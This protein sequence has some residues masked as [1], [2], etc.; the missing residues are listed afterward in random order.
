MLQFALW[1]KILVWGLCAAGIV[2]ALPNGFYSRVERHNDAVRSLDIG[3]PRTP[4]LESELYAW[5]AWLPSK[6]VNLGLD[7]RGGAH[8]LAEVEVNDVYAERMDGMWPDIRDALRTR[9]DSIGTIRRQPAEPSELV[10][11]VSRPEN[12]SVAVEAV[13]ALARPLV[14]LTGAGGSDIEAEAVGDTVVVRLSDAEIAA[15]DERTLRQSLEIIRRR[16]DEVGTRE[17]TIQR[18]G[19]KR[20]LIQVPGIGSA[21]ELKEIIG[22][23]ARLTFHPVVTRTTNRDSTIGPRE[24]LLPSLDEPGQFYVLEKTP[25]VGGED[26][27]DAQPGFDQNGLPAVTFRFNPSGA[28]RFGDYTAANIGSPFA[29]VLDGEVVSA[30]VIQ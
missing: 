13:R 5:P 15:T 25:V 9:R 7:L 6:I 10:V 3:E 4:Q 17:P 21:E 30:P 18:Q 20:I 1:K 27:T 12:I 2:A 24:I 14:S 28:R 23:T 22:T 8:L 26:L 11:R 19:S 16:I 29:I